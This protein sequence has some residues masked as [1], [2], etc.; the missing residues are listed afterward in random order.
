MV[1][2]QLHALFTAVA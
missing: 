1:Q 2:V